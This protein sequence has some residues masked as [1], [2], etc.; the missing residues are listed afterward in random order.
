VAELKAKATALGIAP[1]KKKAD[2]IAAIVAATQTAPVAEPNT[3]SKDAEDGDAVEDEQ[4]LRFIERCDFLA[5]NEHGRVV[6][7]LTGHEMK[8]RFSIVRGC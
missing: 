1:P 2:I 3:E 6:C 5:F 7:T 4:L 8:P